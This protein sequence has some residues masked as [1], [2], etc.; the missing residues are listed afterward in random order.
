M[1]TSWDKME[2]KIEATKNVS[3]RIDGELVT[4][5]EGDTILETAQANGKYI[6]TL[7]YLKGLSAVGGYVRP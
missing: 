4:A 7:C 6:P 2:A 3:L 1:N 5:H